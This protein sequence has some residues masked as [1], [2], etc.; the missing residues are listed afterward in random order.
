VWHLCCNWLYKNKFVP[1]ISEH[2]GQRD[3]YNSE[4]SH[5]RNV[6]SIKQEDN[7][8]TLSEGR[9]SDLLA[10]SLYA[11]IAASTSRSTCYS[12]LH[13]VMKLRHSKHCKWNRR[14]V[15]ALNTSRR[16]N[17][18]YTQNTFPKCLLYNSA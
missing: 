6:Y 8:F 5:L 12:T 15:T 16:R 9:V 3:M 7:R 1:A 4:E 13:E 10:C 18:N 14:V 11:R 17:K 2:Q